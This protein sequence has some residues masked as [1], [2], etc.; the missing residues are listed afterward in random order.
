M[1]GH[2]YDHKNSEHALNYRT[3]VDVLR[4]IAVSLVVFFHAF[5]ELLPGG[6]IGVDIFFVISG[7]LIT[8]IMLHDMKS[9]YFSLS[10]F[11]ARRMRRLFPA[12]ITVLITT[13]IFGYFILFP[14]ELKQVG[15]H[16]SDASV[17]LLNFTLINETGYFDVASHYKPLLHLWSLSIE[18]QFYLIWPLIFLFIW[19]THINPLWVLI[20]VTILSL[21]AMFNL[22]EETAYYHTFTRIWQLSSGAA[23]AVLL[24]VYKPRKPP[25]PLLWLGGFLIGGYALLIE[26][27]NPYR[28]A[29]SVLPIIGTMLILS[30][31]SQAVHNFGFRSLGLISYPL[32][33]WHWVIFSFL[34]IYIGKNPSRLSL[35]IAILLSIFL[36]WLTYQYIEK[37]RYRKGVTAPYLLATL[38]GTGAVGLWV[39]HNDG[40]P[41]REHLSYL[42][43]HNIQFTRTPATDEGCNSY[44]TTTL[45][46]KRLFDYCRSE[47]LDFSDGVVAIIGDSHAHALFPGMAKEAENF[48][49]GI[50]LLANSSCPTLIR[51]EWG[52]ND[53]EIALCKQKIE[54]IFNILKSRKNIKKVIISTRGPVYIHGEVINSMI[55]NNVQASLKQETNHRQTYNTF[56]EGLSLS[57]RTLQ[58]IKHIQLIFYAL[59]NPEIDFIPKEKIERPFDFFGISARNSTI[60]KEAYLLRMEEYRKQVAAAIKGTKTEILDPTPIFCPDTLCISRIK[61]GFLYADDDHFSILGSEY[62]ARYFSRR[63]FNEN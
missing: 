62:V 42:N 36:A 34:T 29:L 19:K 9:G 38:L 48:N 4:G 20:P 46:Q 41:E 50:L 8:N 16:L 14:D 56:R 35:A 40:L 13:G 5:P 51:F 58:E 22:A 3:D 63:I 39:E 52:R 43:N 53:K 32:Y 44:V 37:L 54:Q 1:N 2:S 10:R 24:I 33:L 18:E 21:I 7:F 28:L 47:R 11:Y 27:D 31:N 49:M 12:L 57:L 17:Y 15:Q 55:L 45:K 61:S 30:I 59:E 23:L 25:H 26:G 60:P 6:F